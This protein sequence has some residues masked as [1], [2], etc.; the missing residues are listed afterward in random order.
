MAR[1]LLTPHGGMIRTMLAQAHGCECD[2]CLHVRARIIGA[3][4]VQ[5]SIDAAAREVAS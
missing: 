1:R 5:R 4:R 3:S 2:Y